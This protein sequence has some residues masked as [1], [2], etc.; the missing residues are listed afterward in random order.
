M[1]LRNIKGSKE[2]IEASPYVKRVNKE[3]A[4]QWNT[5]F[6][7]DAPIYLEIGMGKGNFLID[8]A[9]KNSN[10]NYIGIERY[11]SV[12]CRAVQKVE[13]VDP[14][15]NLKFIHMDANQLL[16]VF[17]PEE[18]DKIYLHFSDPWPKERHARRRLNAKEYLS[19]YN[20][21]LKKDGELEM[22]T[23]NLQLFE[24]GLEEAKLSNWIVT[25]SSRNLH[26]QEYLANA[27]I[28]TEYE[29]KFGSVGNPILQ[30][31]V[32]R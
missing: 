32:K 27:P 5:M 21:I 3:I 29:K 11:S 20:V 31:I 23:D 8:S 22:K 30:Y 2:M 4:N 28:M 13:Q 25:K 9:L 14:I 24:F 12:L 17:A 6:S 16:E 15:P 1:R 26:T 19:I 7:N 18:V 10:I